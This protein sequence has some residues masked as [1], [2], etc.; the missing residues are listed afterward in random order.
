[1]Y[2]PNFPTSEQNA[3]YD[4][5]TQKF[6]YSDYTLFEAHGSTSQFPQAFSNSWIGQTIRNPTYFAS[7]SGWKAIVPNYDI[8]IASKNVTL[9]WVNGLGKVLTTGFTD[10]YDSGSLVAGI[11]GTAGI[12]ESGFQICSVPMEY[13]TAYWIEDPSTDQSTIMIARVENA[14]GTL[15]YM[16]CIVDIASASGGSLNFSVV[17]EDDGLSIVSSNSALAA[18][19]SLSYLDD[20]NSCFSATNNLQ[21]GANENLTCTT[22]DW[23]T[24]N[25]TGIQV[26]STPA[27]VPEYPA[28]TPLI[29]TLSIIGAV[30]LTLKKRRKL[31]S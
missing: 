1:M 9:K 18:N 6:T 2:D 3:V 11:E 4:N 13:R 27:S 31:S 29:L 17:P 14:S 12:E 8:V 25:S 16:Q 5:V 21:V 22:A 20:N 30:I 24:L 28:T 26:T 15:S 23:Q 19:V 7:W 10:S